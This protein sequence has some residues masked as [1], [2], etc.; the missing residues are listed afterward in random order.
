[1]IKKN[2]NEM[3]SDKFDIPLNGITSVPNAHFVGNTQL[4]IEGCLGIKKYDDDEIIIS[5]KSFI[6][7]IKGAS[8]SMMSFSLGRVSIKGFI[9]SYSIE[10]MKK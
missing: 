10:R 8:L 4:S 9:S 3:I 7:Y 1:M 6:L 2:L 5:T